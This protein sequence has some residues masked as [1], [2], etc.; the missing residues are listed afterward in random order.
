MRIKQIPED[1]VVEEIAEHDF[2]DEGEYV[3]CH[4]ETKNYTTERAIHEIARRFHLRRKD[5]A[6]AGTKDKRALTR[7]YITIRGRANPITTDDLKVAVLGR[8]SEPLGLGMLEGN[9]FVITLRCLQDERI[10]ELG[11][12]PNYF[13]EQRFSIANDSIGEQIIKNEYGCAVQK[14]IET[15]R[16]HGPRLAGYLEKRENDFVG[17]MRLL[18]QHTLLMYVHAFQSRIWNSLLSRYILA[19]D[20]GAD[21]I[22][23]SIGITIPS[24]EVENIQIPL[25]GFDT[26]LEGEIGGW[27]QE[28][29]KEH[30][31]VQ[32][33][34]VNRQIPFL[35]VEG[36]WRDAF[37][38]ASD[39][40]VSQRA[41]DD[42]N[43]GFEKQTI[44]FSLPSGS[45]ATI[46]V[47]CF[48]RT[49]VE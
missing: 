35:T 14:I 28:I 47:K 19:N 37:V 22:G 42:L 21:S 29:L 45:Y 13:D 31:I 17:A 48:Y 4:L 3:L 34:F 46:A 36:T 39:L 43:E 12:I 32:R 27:A 10:H 49:G 25:I 2:A 11:L 44:S 16:Q 24:K 40:Q 18:P 33:D 30:G 26:S 7:Q 41:S 15:D 20:A 9:R 23:G 1:F 38:R 6:Y 5:I 8:V